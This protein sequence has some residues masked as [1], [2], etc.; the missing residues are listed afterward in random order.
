MF[1][2]QQGATWPSQLWP[3][4]LGI[5]LLEGA[6]S[7]EKCILGVYFRIASQKIGAISL[8]L[9]QSMERAQS[10]HINRATPVY[11]DKAYSIL[12]CRLCHGTHTRLLRKRTVGGDLPATG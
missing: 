4:R 7:R 3:P 11:C 12:L 5:K 9:A 10:G 2:G 1:P 6:S 8:V